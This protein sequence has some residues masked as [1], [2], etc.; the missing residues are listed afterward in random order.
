M[1]YAKMSKTFHIR[2]RIEKKVRETHAER[3]LTTKSVND[4]KKPAS[5]LPNQ[6]C[7][8]RNNVSNPVESSERGKNL[9]THG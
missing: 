6:L 8:K 2:C 9:I 7:A 3:I 4:K 5:I 1:Q